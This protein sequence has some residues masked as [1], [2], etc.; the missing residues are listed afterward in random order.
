MSAL[1]RARNELENRVLGAVTAPLEPP[2]VGDQIV[3]LT[4]DECVSKYPGIKLE[5]ATPGEKLLLFRPHVHN[6]RLNEH[7][8]I[9][10]FIGYY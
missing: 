7:K 1:R 8:V 10:D 3:G 9:K 2:R 6:V 5:V 4:I